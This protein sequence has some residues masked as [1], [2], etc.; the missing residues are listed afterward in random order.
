MRLRGTKFRC[1]GKSETQ[2][3]WLDGSGD[4][5]GEKEVERKKLVF[6]EA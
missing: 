4:D 2:V 1:A 3:F 6:D 5:L